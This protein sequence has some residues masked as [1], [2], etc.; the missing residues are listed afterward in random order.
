MLGMLASSSLDPWLEFAGRLHP[1]VLHTPIGVLAA[2]ATLEGLALATKRPLERRTRVVLALLLAGSAMLSAG[3]GW[4][5]AREPSYG[6]ESLQWH[7]WLGVGFAALTTLSACCVAIGATRWY[8][9]FFALAAIVL[10]PTGHLGGSMTHG[11]KFLFEPFAPPPPPNDPGVTNSDQTVRFAAV[12]R[13]FDAHCVS[14]HGPSKRKGGLAL[15][16]VAA[17]MKGGDA[18]PVVVPGDLEASELIRR[19]HLPNDDDE[20]MPPPEK[21]PLDAASIDLLERWILQGARE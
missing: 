19:L 2:L 5:L 8:A 12:Q 6:G 13:V 21:A 17:T 7:R 9:A 3:S 16:T 1:L 14:C 18:G 10:A 15:N 20:R 11:D 4:L